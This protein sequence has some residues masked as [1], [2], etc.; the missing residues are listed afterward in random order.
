MPFR[1]CLACGTPSPETYCERCKPQR[2]PGATA[3]RGYGGGHQA[4]RDRLDPTVQTG[5]VRC[6]AGAD[7]LRARNGIPDLIHAGEPWDLGH[8]ADRTGYLGPMHAPCNRSR[9]ERPNR[10]RR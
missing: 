7:C 6:A 5:T 3:T 2:P 10:R 9:P 4:E 1:P 8:N